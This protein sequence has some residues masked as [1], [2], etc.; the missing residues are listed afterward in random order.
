MDCSTAHVVV[1][2]YTRNLPGPSP[3]P[4]FL[5]RYL[6]N[7]IWSWIGIATTLVVGFFLSPFIIRH[8]GDANFGLWSLTLAFVEYYWVVDLG[9]RSATLKY[10]AQYRAEGNNAALNE[11]LSTGL[12][13]SVVMA[14]GLFSLTL[15]LAPYLGKLLHV[16]QPVFASLVRIIGL[17]WG[18]GLVFGRYTGFLEGFQRF[19]LTNRLW[20]GS[21]ALRAV[22]LIVVLAM[23]RGLVEMAWTL[24]ACNFLMYIGG[25]LQLRREF[26]AY[27][28]SWRKAT[29]TM[30]RRMLGYGVHS[31]TILISNRAI[32]L[33]T[34]FL[35]TYFLSVRFVAYYAVPSRLLDYA[36]EGIGRIGMITA[37]SAADLEV[38]SG[39]AAL[40]RLGILTNR[41]CLAI[42]LPVTAFLAIYGFEFV[43]R[44]IRPDFAAQSAFLF[45]I[46]LIGTTLVAGQLNSVSILTGLA[47]HMNYARTLLVEAVVSIAAMSVCLPRFGLLG[48]GA[49]TATLAALNRGLITAILTSRELR[50]PLLRYL[51]AIYLIPCAAAAP[52][53][54]ALWLVKWRFLPGRTWPQLIAAALLF[55]VLYAP[56]AFRFA[57]APEH[58]DRLLQAARS[59]I[60]RLVPGFPR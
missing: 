60:P 16:D 4:G 14:V 30:L 25:Y 37:P 7:A 57:L 11:L 22:V 52:A 2:W 6:I 50:F 40:V 12:V 47:R 43:A 13:Y 18:I 41:Y 54:A 20:I 32:N 27:D 49:V 10:A 44:W 3:A 46:L 33:S 15:V 51:S 39:R 55:C 24:L 45:P 1:P 34:P 48:A 53:A 19:D 29:R 35:I 8:I 17:N 28:V 59:R 5:R 23:G 21:T 38:K 9:F 31:L 26:P 42:Y 58:R 36:M 56:L